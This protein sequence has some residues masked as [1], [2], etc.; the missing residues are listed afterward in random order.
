MIK[1]LIAAT[2]A[3]GTFTFS[4]AN[5]A[6][7]PLPMKAPPP[8]PPAWTWTGCYG[9]IEGGGTIGN[10]R[11]KA[12]TGAFAGTTVTNLTPTGGL[13]G[14][15]I[16]CNYQFARFVVIGIEDDISWNGLRGSFADQAPFAATFSHSVS[17]NWLDTLRGRVGIA[18]WDNA[19]FYATGGVAFA[20][21]QDS[22]TGPGGVGASAN[23]TATGWTVGGG[24]EFMPFPNWSIKVEYLFVQFPTI[25]DGFN[26]APP[27]GTF[28]GVT[29]HLSENVI[30][31]GINWHFNWWTPVATR[32]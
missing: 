28:T 2:V 13:G 10:D 22:V 7:L 3:L 29:T 21:I 20:G 19:L 1:R 12:N 18:T 11:V 27:A 26:V 5:A 17:S 23:S 8:P 32:Y 9:G 25:T 4:G 24:A 16:G 30:R 6:D 15:T 31:V 14:G